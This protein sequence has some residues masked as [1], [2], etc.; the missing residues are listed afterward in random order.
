MGQ[1][2]STRVSIDEKKM[3]K[4]KSNS[5]PDPCS[6]LQMALGTAAAKNTAKWVNNSPITNA[7]FADF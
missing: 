7:L 4:M 3:R 2:A 1:K 5:I 6:Y